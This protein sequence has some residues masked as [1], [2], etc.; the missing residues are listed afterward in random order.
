MSTNLLWYGSI[1]QAFPPRLV[2]SLLVVFV[3]IV[4]IVPAVAG[5]ASV[6]A[7]K[8]MFILDGSGSMWGRVRDTSGEVEKIV[9]AKRVVSNLIKQ[10]PASVQVGLEVYGHR[11]KTDCSD[12]EVMLPIGLDNQAAAIEKLDSIKPKGK[13]PISQALLV[14]SKQLKSLDGAATVVLVSDGK[15][16]CDDD[17]CALVKSLR[18]QGV[19][20]QVHVVGFDV[21]KEERDQLI[22]IA[23][24]GKG[25]YFTANNADQ[26]ADS[27]AAINQTLT[28]Q[29]CAT[30]NPF[31]VKDVPNPFD[32]GVREFSMNVP[33]KAKANDPNA[34]EWAASHNY[35]K[36]GSIDG[37][38]IARWNGGGTGANWIAGTADVRTVKDVVYILY[39][40]ETS[41]YL[42]EA[43]LQPEGRLVGKYVNVLQPANSTPWVGNIVGNNRI[44]GY[45]GG[46]RWDY[47]R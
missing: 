1:S 43:K 34:S 13:T 33:A 45:W 27:F 4:S 8:V 6:P 31:C 25:T 23:D 20:M 32:E 18:E 39:K 2:E 5:Q 47:R 29:R 16:T 7:E 17:P 38:W 26:L 22:C 41:T 28:Q 15:E 46:G 42:T 37:Y 11:S 19:N 14:A 3:L 30:R 24:A 21:G 36:Q 40:D 44:D 9:V 10:L 35:N 12:V